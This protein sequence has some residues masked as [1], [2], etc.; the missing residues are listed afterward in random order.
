ML[1]E[2]QLTRSSSSQKYMIHLSK[3]S[4]CLNEIIIDPISVQIKNKKIYLEMKF[5]I[6]NQNY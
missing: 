4:K 1:N 6:K 5:L 3:I 2:L